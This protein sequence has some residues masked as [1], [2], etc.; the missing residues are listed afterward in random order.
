MPTG[1]GELGVHGSREWVAS[2]LAAVEIGCNP[3]QLLAVMA[4]RET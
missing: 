1:I 3:L 4:P 2:I